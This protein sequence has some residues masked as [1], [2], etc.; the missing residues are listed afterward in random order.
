MSCK[1]FK[2]LRSWQALSF[3]VVLM[4]CSVS[5]A[6][7][8]DRIIATVN[9]EPITLYDLNKAMDNINKE[10]LKA[11]NAKIGSEEIQELRKRAFNHLIDEN[12]ISQELVKKGVEAT[13]QEVSRAIDTILQ[14]NKFTLDQLKKELASKGSSLDAYREDIK[15]QVK[16]VKFINQIVG[17]KIKINEEDVKAFYAQRGAEMGGD[18][19]IHIAQ[20][21]VPI[22][23][24]PSTEEINKAKEKSSQIYQ[25]LKGGMKFDQAMKEYGG[26]GSGDLG[27]I[28]F[29]GLNPEL[30][31][32]IQG[33]SQ[34]GVSEPIQ[35]PAGYIIVKMIEKPD[36]QLAGSEDIKN[37]IRD[38][39]YEMKVQEEIKK[40]VDQ[41]RSKSF[42]DVKANI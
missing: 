35:S 19:Q 30:A 38:K 8:V 32:A 40:Y 16:R 12:L 28:G 11:P 7:I 33:L 25:K 9:Q 5:R 34:G 2:R 27:K 36:V 10:L 15:N 39:I 23:E 13:D 21:V 42:I 3:L 26:V 37:R 41:L 4:F 20:I 24:S 1:K 14:R 18:Q 29:S 31:S 17:N 22:S 6:E